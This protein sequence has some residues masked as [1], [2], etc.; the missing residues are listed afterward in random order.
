MRNGTTVFVGV[1]ANMEGVNVQL[2][3]T[4][5]TMSSPFISG[6]QMTDAGG[7]VTL[8]WRVHVLALVGK[9]VT[10]RVVAITQGPNGQQISSQPVIVQILVK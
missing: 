8:P 10:A 4:Y 5:N 9:F 2:L 7:N 3:V 6:T 1:T